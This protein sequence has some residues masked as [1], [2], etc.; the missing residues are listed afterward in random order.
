MGG[1]HVAVHEENASACGGGKLGGGKETVGV[2]AACEREVERRRVG[3]QAERMVQADGEGREALWRG[4]GDGY[5]AAE[6]RGVDSLKRAARG[7]K[8]EVEYG[9]V[10]RCDAAEG[11]AGGLDNGVRLGGADEFGEE[12]LVVDDGC[13]HAPADGFDG[14]WNLCHCVSSWVIAVS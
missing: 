1:L 12:R 8:G 14:K 2:A 3:W 6:R 9:G 7:R 10:R 4:E 5:D 11:E 13:R